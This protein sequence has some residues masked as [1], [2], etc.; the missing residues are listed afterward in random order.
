MK[1]DKK[2]LEIIL[3]RLEGI[4]NPSPNLEQQETPPD[5]ASSIISLASLM[6]D[7]KG[8]VIDL[9][10]GSGILS[11]GS[12]LAGVEKVVGIDI[13]PKAVATAWVNAR[14]VGVKERVRFYVRDVRDFKERGDLVIQNPPFGVVRRHMDVVF[15]ETAFRSADVVYSIHLAGNKKFIDQFAALH[16][17]KVTHVERWSFPI[18]RRFWYHRKKVVEVPVDVYRFERG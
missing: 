6:G 2:V 5:L 18:P 13:D 11:I 16:G 3:G 1:V 14:K 8:K 10:C 4:P 9:G 17:F 7:L 15:L 12:A